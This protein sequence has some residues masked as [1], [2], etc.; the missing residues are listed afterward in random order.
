MQVLKRP[1][2]RNV[3]ELVE[4]M[5]LYALFS[6]DVIVIKLQKLF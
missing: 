5:S 4:P 1:R 2:K 6:E 3:I